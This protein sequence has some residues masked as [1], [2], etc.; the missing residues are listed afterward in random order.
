MDSYEAP[1]L[2]FI[3]A[4]G[5]PCEPGG[6]DVDVLPVVESAVEQS[7]P[8]PQPQPQPQPS[9]VLAATRAR[10]E[11]PD[12]GCTNYT[13]LMDGWRGASQP[14]GQ[15]DDG[16]LVE[17]WYRFTGAEGDAMAHADPGAGGHCG[18]AQ[19]GWLSGCDQWT[20]D[21][22][23]WAC[24]ANGSIPIFGGN[25]NATVCFRDQGYPCR[26]IAH[27]QVISCFEEGNSFLV[28]YLQPLT[29]NADGGK[30]YCAGASGLPSPEPVPEPEPEPE[31]E[32]AGYDCV[33]IMGENHCEVVQS[34][35]FP[36]YP[37]KV[38][39]DAECAAPSGLAGNKFCCGY[40]GIDCSGSS[41]SQLLIQFDDSGDGTTDS[42]DIILQTDGGVPVMCEDEAVAYDRASGQLRFP[43]NKT[44]GDCLHNV[45]SAV[46]GGR[47]PFVTYISTSHPKS[48]TW[49]YGD[50]AP[51]VLEEGTCAPPPAPPPSPPTI[52]E[53][54]PDGWWYK[55]GICNPVRQAEVPAEE[56]G[57]DV[58][59]WEA[60]VVQFARNTSVWAEQH[61][62]QSVGTGVTSA[63][64]TQTGVE[65]IW[66]DSQH[67][68]DGETTKVTGNLICDE[69]GVGTIQGMDLQDFRG[70]VR[71]FSFD[72]HTEA[73]CQDWPPPP[74]PPTYTPD[75]CVVTADTC[76]C[77]GTDVTNL[78]GTVTLLDA[79]KSTHWAY[80]LG[81]C[82]PVERK[83]LPVSCA[84]VAANATALRYETQ[85][86]DPGMMP[87]CEQ[88][89]GGSVKATHTEDAKG[90]RDGVDIIY[91]FESSQ[92]EGGCEV[93]LRVQ[94]SSADASVRPLSL[95]SQS[96]L[97]L[98]VSSLPFLPFDVSPFW[99]PLRTEQN[100]PRS[101]SS[102]LL[103]DS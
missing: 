92:C 85:S 103:S 55:V 1:G 82:G 86:S 38:A 7:E 43:K 96:L 52:C 57:H 61:G 72:W 64:R 45:D 4:E 11:D 100:R 98:P 56:C 75:L 46:G 18:T 73:A 16:S 80:K 12:P 93:N 76:T 21:A 39:C 28:W 94:C 79:D 74:P 90:A 47:V 32:V 60:G 101:V 68:A 66:E 9:P 53:K 65:L 20:D 36:N 99:V 78:K 102:I 33:E 49:A 54:K 25:P 23:G 34:P 91:S 6:D 37:N 63:T 15:H 42:A 58:D 77:D 17:G 62:C 13:V 84:N 95:H 40:G 87:L 10:A 3:D 88:L 31:P 69:D 27:T 67:G 97:S 71:E 70:E 19:P 26:S 2:S 50:G 44:A 81:V 35:A 8:Q 41:A 24:D 14:G 5:N 29:A 83:G 22:A 30:A 59:S 51:I 89:G 48:L